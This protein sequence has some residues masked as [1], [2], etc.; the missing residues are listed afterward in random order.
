MGLEAAIAADHHRYDGLRA[1]AHGIT[2]ELRVA[3][4][5]RLPQLRLRRAP[6]AT[7][8]SCVAEH[9]VGAGRHAAHRAPRR[10]APL[11]RD[12]LRHRRGGEGQGQRR[13]TDEIHARYVVVADGSRLALRPGARHRPQPG[14]PAGHGHPGLLREP[15]A[16]RPVDR[17][18]P[19]TCA[20]ATAHSLPGYGWI[21][22]VGD[23]TINVGIG[24]L[25]TFR[26]Y[27]D[28]NTTHLMREWAATAPEH[29]GID[30]DAML[31]P[32][33]G[34]RLPMA[35]SV[36]PKVGPNWMRRRRRRR[37]DQPVQ[38]RGHRLRLRD[39]PHGRRPARRGAGAPAT[40]SPCSATRRCSTTS[41][42]STSR[43]PALSPRSSASPRSCAS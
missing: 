38:R 33:T 39:R 18:V 41:T 30:P 34:G 12:G 22:P 23:G 10:C 42:A 31:A 2:L 7:S 17:D 5:P 8:T 40:A 21:F 4:A 15:A 24:L 35:G 6:R 27:K 1:V 36:N 26:D 9:A 20:T 29:W 28:V 25:S 43:W 32:P 13:Q 19:S 11:L 14:L 16:R 3:R 37:V